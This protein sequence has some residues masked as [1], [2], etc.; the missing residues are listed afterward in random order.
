VTGKSSMR[1]QVEAPTTLLG[2]IQA[3]LLYSLTVDIHQVGGCQGALL[4]HCLT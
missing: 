2:R 3:A 1:G 4:R